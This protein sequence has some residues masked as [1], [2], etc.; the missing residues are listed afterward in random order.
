MAASN[1]TPGSAP[2]GLLERRYAAKI[3]GAQRVRAASL[4]AS[5]QGAREEATE[6]DATTLQDGQEDCEQADAAQTAVHLVAASSPDPYR[7]ITL[8]E[9]YFL[10]QHFSFNLNPAST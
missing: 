1:G 7:P 8:E 2:P 4:G 9:C 10:A 6:V 3:M 5:E